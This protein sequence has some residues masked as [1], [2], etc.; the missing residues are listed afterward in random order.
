MCSAPGRILLLSITGR[1]DWR[2]LRYYLLV[3]PVPLASSKI[4]L[5]SSTGRPGALSSIE[6]REGHGVL[7]FG[8]CGCDANKF[9]R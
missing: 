9:E 7:E 2:A 3:V 5:T 6:H 8:I 4:L 1:S